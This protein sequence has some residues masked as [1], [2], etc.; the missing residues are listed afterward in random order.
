M[1]DDKYYDYSKLNSI[2][3]YKPGKA[4]L[5]AFSK[6]TLSARADENAVQRKND[7]AQ[8]KNAKAQAQLLS[9]AKDSINQSATQSL[10]GGG[11]SLDSVLSSAV[12]SKISKKAGQTVMSGGSLDS[13][14]SNLGSKISKKV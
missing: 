11:G 12:G 7:L 4:K 8:A 1:A 13:V 2:S 14:L 9:S 3:P 6:N 10:T 5:S